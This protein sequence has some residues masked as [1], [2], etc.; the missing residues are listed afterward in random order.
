MSTRSVLFIID[1]MELESGGIID[2]HFLF[3]HG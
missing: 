1:V 3:E 2:I